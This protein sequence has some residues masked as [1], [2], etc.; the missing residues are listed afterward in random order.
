MC[1]SVIAADP[2]LSDFVQHFCEELDSDGPSL[3]PRQKP[4]FVSLALALAFSA[5][6]LLRNFRA[7][8][9]RMDEVQEPA[10]SAICGATNIALILPAQ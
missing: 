1:E 7:V 6:L 2:S 4:F 3:P 9:S 5:G 8:S 10:D